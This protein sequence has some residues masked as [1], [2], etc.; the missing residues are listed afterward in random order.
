MISITFSL[1]EDQ[2]R[3]IIVH[4]ETGLRV[5]VFGPEIDG[6]QPRPVNSTIRFSAIPFKKRIFGKIEIGRV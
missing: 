3:D 4:A 6:Y 1:P 5:H 2:E